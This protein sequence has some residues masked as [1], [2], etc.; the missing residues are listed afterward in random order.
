[1]NEDG[2]PGSV[3]RKMV[4]ER[5]PEFNMV[6]NP[7]IDPSLQNISTMQWGFSDDYVYNSPDKFRNGKFLTANMV[8]TDVQRTD[9]EATGFGMASGS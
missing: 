2:T 7:G 9:N 5:Y 6:M 8:Y 3:K 4:V 1:M